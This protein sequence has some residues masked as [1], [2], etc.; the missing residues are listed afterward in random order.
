MDAAL[1]KETIELKSEGTQRRSWCY[2]ADCVSGLFSILLKG[3]AG[4]AYNVAPDDAFTIS[5]MAE[6][7]ADIAG[8]RVIY[9]LRPTQENQNFNPMDIAVLSTEKLKALGWRS[10]FSLKDGINST[11]QIMRYSEVLPDE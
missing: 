10:R 2:V 3:K 4:E 1:H 5:E 8:K 9:K 7:V 6:T 11:L